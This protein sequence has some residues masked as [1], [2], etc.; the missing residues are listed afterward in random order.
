MESMAGHGERERVSALA[1]AWVLVAGPD[2]PAAAR[3]RARLA[4]LGATPGELAQDAEDAVTPAAAARPDVVLA[5][6]GVG[7]ALRARLDPLGL[8]GGPPVV[9]VDDI[10]G[11]PGGTAGDEA[12]LDRLALVLERH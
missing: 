4:E 9:A 10:D 1:G 12:V 11:L 7:G 3:L 6:P 5:L 8:G 2:A